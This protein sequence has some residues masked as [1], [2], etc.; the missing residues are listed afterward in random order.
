MELDKRIKDGRR[1]FGCFD[2][3]EAEG[4]MNKVCYFTHDITE[5]EDIKVNMS[6]GCIAR[7]CLTRIEPDSDSHKF[8]WNESEG[9]EFCIPGDYVSPEMSFRPYTLNEWRRTHVLGTEVVFRKKRRPTGH[10]M[11]IMHRVFLGYDEGKQYLEKIHLGYSALSLDTL[12]E[13]YEIYE[14]GNW[15]T[16]GVKNV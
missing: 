15:R 8:F 13:K 7:G 9:F 6:R 10:S 5:F 14:D 12:F 2:T 4:F 1:P 11:P 16:F 3:K